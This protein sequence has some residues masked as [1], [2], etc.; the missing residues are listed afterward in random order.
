L[1]ARPVTSYKR[2]VTG[3]FPTDWPTDCPPR[4][5]VSAS[6]HVF[7]IVKQAPP[8]A[9]D[10]VTH[11]EAGTYRKAPPC[12]RAGL[13]VFRTLD[14]AVHQR[15]LFP[16]LGEHIA[17]GSLAAHHGKTKLT[18]GRQPSHTTWW[19]HVAVTRAAGFSV[20]RETP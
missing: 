6:G 16:A 5:A 19:P 4:D 11:H 3:T 17:R 12:L 1:A 15:E 20:V 8:A 18:Q 9:D 2:T 14:D 10:F 7:R 13:S